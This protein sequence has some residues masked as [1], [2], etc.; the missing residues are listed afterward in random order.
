MALIPL[1][2]FFSVTINE[3]Q[4]LPA[5][6]FYNEGIPVLKEQN[7]LPAFQALKC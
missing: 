2:L 5:Q 7:A 3:I 1:C 6:M 4:T